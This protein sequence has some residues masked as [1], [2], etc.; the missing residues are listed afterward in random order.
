MGERMQK[1]ALRIWIGVGVIS[2]LILLT[3]INTAVDRNEVLGFTALG[4]LAYVALLWNTFLFPGE[5][6]WMKANIYIS[7]GLLVIFFFGLTYQYFFVPDDCNDCLLSP[8]GFW[9]AMNG[10][11]IFLAFVH[12]LTVVTLYWSYVRH[13]KFFS[14]LLLIALIIPLIPAIPDFLYEIGL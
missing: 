1:M 10:L 12:N 5:S 14:I 8:G 3:L 4:L 2:T 7:W 11:A 13:R 6:K 9:I